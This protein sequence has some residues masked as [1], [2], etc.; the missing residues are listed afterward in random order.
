MIV[1]SNVGGVLVGTSVTFTNFTHTSPNAVG[2]LVMSPGQQDTLL[3][4][5]VGTPN[6]GA[7]NVTITFSDAATNS[8]PSTTTVSTPITNGVYKPTQDAAIPNFP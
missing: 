1:V 3:M 6:V 8:L 2:A 5:G 7:N 4:S